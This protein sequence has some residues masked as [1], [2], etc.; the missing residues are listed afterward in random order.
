VKL[1]H[2]TKEDKPIHGVTTLN[3]EIYVRHGDAD[4][5]VYDTETFTA[6]RSLQ[7]P[8]LGGVS[9]MTSCKRHQCVYISDQVKKV[10]HRVDDKN[11]ITQWPVDD[12]PGGLSVNS[13]HNVLVTC[14]VVGKVKEFA[15]DGKLIREICMESSIVN[16]SHAVE[17]TTGQL[18]VCH[19]GA[20][21]AVHR[22]CKVDSSGR[23]L[24]SYGGSKGS[25]S[26]QMNLPIR[27]AASAGVIFVVDCRNQRVLMLSSTLSLIR[28]VVSGLRD[29]CRTWFNDETG[30][31]HVAENK[32]ENSTWVGS[33]FVG[34][35]FV[36]GKL[37]VYG[38]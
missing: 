19:G 31:L 17:L 2:S 21:D 23:V 30:R 33:Q 22:V 26:G 32:W 27:L 24:Q 6:Q 1:V 9:D 7:I 4:I 38:V 8:S 16:P 3:H 14:D 35:R 15:T 28:A 34:G 37:I 12:V 11:T 10:V 29:P 13:D 20:N 5:R 18:V 25:G 36:S